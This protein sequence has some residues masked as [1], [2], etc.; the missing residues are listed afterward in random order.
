MEV[1]GQRHAPAALSLGFEDKVNRICRNVGTCSPKDTV[2]HPTTL[3]FSDSA[4]GTSNSALYLLC[5]GHTDVN[6]L[7]QNMWSLS[8]ICMVVCSVSGPIKY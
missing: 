5:L 6:K 2:S 1:G 4:V 8:L 7:G 3:I